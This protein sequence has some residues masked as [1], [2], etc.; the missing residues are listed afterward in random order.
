M[1]ILSK[2]IPIWYRYK[3]RFGPDGIG[4]VILRAKSLL[5]AGAEFI[6]LHPGETMDRIEKL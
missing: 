4:S 3:V 5:E 6:R 2:R 1:D